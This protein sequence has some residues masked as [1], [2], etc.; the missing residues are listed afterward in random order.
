MN[1]VGSGD[2]ERLPG[3]KVRTC[4]AADCAGLE[5]LGFPAQ[6]PRHQAMDA[7]VSVPEGRDDRPTSITQPA[8]WTSGQ[9][10]SHL[11]FVTNIRALRCQDSEIAASHP[12]SRLGVTG[13][14]SS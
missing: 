12:P 2:R 1:E 9:T 6:M 13:R 14:E 10:N 11:N 3:Y 7:L 4:H 8:T 5:I